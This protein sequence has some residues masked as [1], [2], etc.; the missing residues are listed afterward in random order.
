[1]EYCIVSIIDKNSGKIMEEIASDNLAI[2][3]Q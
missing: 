1:M 3:I 2:A